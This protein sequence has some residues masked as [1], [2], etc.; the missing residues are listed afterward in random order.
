MKLLK[1]V[2]VLLAL[3]TVLM[4][5]PASVAAEDAPPL[6]A[7]IFDNKEAVAEVNLKENGYGSKNDGYKATSGDTSAL[8]FASVNGTD[9]RK[10]EWSKDVYGTKG[11]QPAMTGG[12]NNPW[13]E[14]GYLEV[15]MS[16][17]GYQ[18]LAFY[19]DLGA[20]NKGPRDYKLQYSVDGKTFKDVGVTYAVEENKTMETA[21][22]NVA[23]PAELANKETVYIR[24]T[25][26]SDATVG[27]ETG[28]KGSTG[29]ETAV[30]NILI[31]GTKLDGAKNGVQGG[32]GDGGG[33]LIWALIG[34]GAVV[35]IAV[36]SVTVAIVRKKKA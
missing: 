34:G 29:G 27:G 2:A 9:L 20:T 23:L 22:D 14:G 15:R 17:L 19:A 26:A 12:N 28:L 7:F 5:V 8:L 6:A 36:V 3:A 24:I 25:V 30:N 10:L 1:S 35:L 31:Y 18:S 11:M 4:L 33:W 21:F 32:D 13:G 16:T